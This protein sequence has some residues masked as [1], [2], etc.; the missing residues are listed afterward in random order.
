MAED[1]QP[2]APAAAP[3][4]AEGKTLRW[5]IGSSALQV[6]EHVYTME[7]FPGL[8]TRRDLARQ[9]NVSARQVQVWFQNKRQRERKIS[10]Q[11]G[12]FSTPGLP[13]TPA[14]T[15]AKAAASAGNSGGG[16]GSSS[17]DGKAA[18]DGGG[19]AAPAGTEAV[20]AAAA[21]AANRRTRRASSSACARTLRA[22][23]S[24]PSR[25]TGVRSLCSSPTTTAAAR[26][27]RTAS[28]TRGRRAR[29]FDPGEAALPA[30]HWC[31]CCGVLSPCRE[32]LFLVSARGHA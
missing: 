1:P 26:A 9:L 13:D 21:A 18:G 2:A 22:A 23:G 19:A 10:K 16:A 7:P 6:L 28:S 14:T 15:A 11:M 27:R 30:E 24:T 29:I 20:A 32:R 31:W 4:A 3:T 12:L 17:A 5:Q 25:W 8:E